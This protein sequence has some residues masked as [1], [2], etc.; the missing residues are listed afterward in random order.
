MVNRVSAPFDIT[1]ATEGP[2]AA[3]GV[4]GVSLNVQAQSPKEGTADFAGLALGI[5]SQYIQYET[6]Q[7]KQD[8]GYMKGQADA[9]AKAIDADEVGFFQRKAY[10]EGVG[11]VSAVTAVSDMQARALTDMQKAIANGTDPVTYTKQLQQNAVGVLRNSENGAWVLNK[12]DHQHVINGLMQTTDTLARQYKQQWD[13]AQLQLQ[14]EGASTAVMNA[15]R[16]VQNAVTPE[17]VSAATTALAASQDIFLDPKAEYR[18]STKDAANNFEQSLKSLGTT[19]RANGGP[20]DVPRINAMVE[21]VWKSPLYARMPSAERTQINT[22]LFNIREDVMGAQSVQ[23]LQTIKQMT[24]D[25]QTGGLAAG[26]FGMVKADLDYADRIVL[27]NYVALHDERGAMIPVE[28]YNAVLDA[29]NALMDALGKAG[30][31]HHL[32]SSPGAAASDKDAEEVHKLRREALV[33]EGVPG[34]I[35]DLRA[36]LVQYDAGVAHSSPF[37][38]QRGQKGV[39]SFL[40]DMAEG[41]VD[42]PA[43]PVTKTPR[44]PDHAANL[45][46]RVRELYINNPVEYARFTAGLDP[47]YQ[48][49]LAETMARTGTSTSQVAATEFRNAAESVRT[50]L[51]PPGAS[52]PSGNL[53]DGLGANFEV[54]GWGTRT[55]G[56]MKNKA[57]VLGDLVRGGI[58]EDEKG[59]WAARYAL[60][61][62]ARLAYAEEY[63][64]RAARNSLPPGLDVDALEPLL[65]GGVKSRHPNTDLAPTAPYSTQVALNSPAFQQLGPARDAFLDAQYREYALKNPTQNVLGAT[66]HAMPGGV[67]IRLY[68]E[69][70]DAPVNLP[71]VTDE[72]ISN[73]SL[74]NKVRVVNA[75]Q[76]VHAMGTIAVDDYTTGRSEVVTTRGVNKFQIPQAE[77]EAFSKRVVFFE[78]Y[79][80]EPDPKHGTI[81]IGGHPS[82]RDVLDAAKKPVPGMESLH[83]KFSRLPPQERTAQKFY[84]LMVDDPRGLAE[85]YKHAKTEATALGFDFIGR[86]YQDRGAREL[87]TYSAY[88]GGPSGPKQV[89]AILDKWVKRGFSSWDDQ[90]AAIAELEQTRVWAGGND[91]SRPF[92]RAMLLQSIDGQ[93]R[94]FAEPKSKR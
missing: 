32:M 73:W 5:A 3:A 61:E 66:L 11:R 75:S 62:G 9:L 56:W 52:A 46:Q 59:R 82:Q 1:V 72:A 50:G 2:R 24:Q 6:S 18:I 13:S 25:V 28:A 12:A 89:G 55:S 71:V 48:G 16:N 23:S 54:L 74:K 27:S 69:Q 70:S 57:A 65:R 85:F 64:G 81:G 83:T 78:Q 45:M 53:P 14:Q 43:D 67:G 60:S 10:Q 4:S 19:M 40:L 93:A 30:K 20:L 80:S 88:L 7:Q 76:G 42:A 84:D 86:S 44:Y 77:A 91:K 15:A 94:T 68:T 37:H 38:L 26:R 21:A 51:R 47:K 79:R 34:T 33:A 58:S 8:E 39:G 92:M 22:A 35:A 87:L 31:E 49:V 17:D 63:R 90:R 29:R 41:R 36:S